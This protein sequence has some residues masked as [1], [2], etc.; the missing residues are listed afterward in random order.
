MI[1]WK[2]SV[3]D[4]SNVL[5]ATY[6]SEEVMRAALQEYQDWCANPA[7]DDHAILEVHGFNDSSDRSEQVSVWRME[8]IINILL[9]KQW[10]E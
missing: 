7:R 9:V 4:R 8:A 6:G 2:F 1:I 10:G 5:M 3:A